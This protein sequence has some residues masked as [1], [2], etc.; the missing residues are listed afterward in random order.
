MKNIALVYGGGGSE[1]EISKISAQFLSEQID[2]KDFN[3]KVFE[4][5][6]NFLFTSEDKTYELSANKSFVTDDERFTVDYV[7][8]CIHGYPGE[9]GDFQSLLNA[10]SIPYLGCG[11]EASTICFNKA[12]TKLMLEHHGVQTTPFIS[13]DA[14]DFSMA[15]EFFKKHKTVFVKATNQG[16]SIGC[17]KVENTKDLENKITEAFKF[18]NSVIIESFIKAREIEVA[19]FEFNAKVNATHPAEI[20]CTNNFYD[21]EE[22][23]SSTSSTKTIIKA[24]IDPKIA[25]QINDISQ[26]VFKVLKLKDLSRIDFFLDHDKIFVNEI[27]TF[28]GMTAISM[29]PKMMKEHGVEFKSFIKERINVQR[30]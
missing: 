14:H 9:S 20:I 3:L 5:D 16:S 28:P 22:K 8:P 12:I 7:I 10:Y 19:V 4:L 2:S 25:K 17:Y 30:Q 29:F 23:Y 24:D 21:Y 26:K 1:H 13:A 11:S 18:S 27:N 15:H 6:K